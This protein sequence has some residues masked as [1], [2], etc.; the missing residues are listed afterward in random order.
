MR[1]AILLLLT[2]AAFAAPPHIVLFIADDY[3]WHD[4][5]AYGNKDV[6]TP[7][8][9]KLASQGMRFNAAFA[10]SPTC[11]PSRS[12]IYTGLY[13]HHNGAHANHSLINDNIRTLPAQMKDLGYRAVIAGK[14]HIGPRALFPFEYLKDS[15]IMPA[16]KNHV[17]WTDL[18]TTAVEQLL[19]DHPRD[20]PLCLIVCSHSPHVY[21]PD[22]NGYDPA[23]LTVP[24]YLLDTPETRAA[25]ARYY[26]D[27]TWMDKQL[28][29]VLASLNKHN[30]TDNTLFIFTADQ[31]AQFPFAK[32]NL[33]DA[34]LR[35]PLIMR[36]PGK[37]RPGTSDAPVS[38]VDLLPTMI[39]SAGGK[40][41][42]GLDGQTL[43]SANARDAI[44]AAHTGDGQMNRSPMRA[45]RTSKYKYILNLNPDEPY[46]THISEGV[47]LDGRDY[48]ASWTKLA[49]TDERAAAIVK[50]YRTRPAEELYDVSKDPYE[51]INLA[52]DPAHAQTKAQLAQKLKAWRITQGEDLTKVLMPEDARK[53]EVPYAK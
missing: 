14:T 49:E 24:P 6:R 19:A 22:N 8:I 1:F 17:L 2:S 52:S 20:A 46:K 53:G 44:F 48:W 21:W 12:A 50:R 37:T 31:G 36:W 42:A 51:L 7:N 47:T 9:D 33:Y 5:S 27:V 16:G 23:K 34:G 18:N 10:A 30:F 45:I 13:P 15:N 35:V 4:S 41:P 38:L 32:W 26:T 29:D 3:S 40:I 11:T 39:E 25:L 28:G 43:V